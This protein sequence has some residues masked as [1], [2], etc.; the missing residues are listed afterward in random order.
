MLNIVSLI[1]TKAHDTLIRLCHS[2]IFIC[3]KL[4]NLTK[5]HWHSVAFNMTL[6]FL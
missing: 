4:T 6:V 3:V 2:L 5:N 1:I